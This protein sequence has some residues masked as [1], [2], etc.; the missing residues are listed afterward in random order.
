MTSTFCDTEPG[1]S[2][3]VNQPS[4]EMPGKSTSLRGFIET[5]SDAGRLVQVSERTHW[6]FDLGRIT[7]ESKT[8]LLFE[9][10]V[11]YPGQR[12]FTNG[13][14]DT[15]LIGLALGLDRGISREDLIAELGQRIANP[16]SP[17]VVE[18]GPVLDNIL[19]GRDVNLLVLPIPHWNENDCGRYLGTW[20]TNVTKD[21]ETGIRN[22]GVYRM[23][24]LGANQA[25]VST[26]PQSHLAQHFAK[27]E[28]EGRALPMAVAVGTNEA[29]VMAAAAGYPSGMDEYELAGGLQQQAVEVIRCKTVDIEVPA[30]S[31]IVIEG[32]IQPGVRVQDGPYFDYSGTTSTNPSAFLF[33]ASR[34]MFRNNPIFRG[35]SIG[36]PGA[37]D[38]QLFAVLAE[39]GLLD[40][41]RSSVKKGIQD[42]VLKQRLLRWTCPNS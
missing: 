26:S 13:L 34:I 35:T 38:H 27:A 36:V 42:M 12:V 20:H 15:E 19:Q 16:V 39:L 3:P 32:A 40:F 17:R 2:G 14:R 33:E 11:D 6:R 1:S 10:I 28:R 18:T 29:V 37:E 8:P 24:L 41:H 7:R 5:L 23:Q 21:P 25:T 31:E 22:V 9:N 30:N 4:Q